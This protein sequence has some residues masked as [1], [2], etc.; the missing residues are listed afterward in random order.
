MEERKWNLLHV[1]RRVSH[2][3]EMSGNNRQIKK[4]QANI[5]S[6]FVRAQSLL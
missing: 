3:K 6:L 4:T 1:L 5:G 2:L